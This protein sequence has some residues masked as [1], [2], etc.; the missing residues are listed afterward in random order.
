MIRGSLGCAVAVVLDAWL[1]TWV[2]TAHPGPLYLAGFT[3]SHSILCALFAIGIVR[4][5]PAPYRIRARSSALFVF[6]LVLFIPVFG[7][8]YLGILLVPALH[9]GRPTVAGTRHAEVCALPAI[10]VEMRGNDVARGTDLPG[11]LRFATDPEKRIA[12]LIATLS[13]DDR[14]AVR[15]LRLALKDPEDEIRLLAYA[16]LTRKEKAI[17][18]RI[19]DHQAEKDTGVSKHQIY[20][21]HKALAHDYWELAHIGGSQ[22]STMLSLCARAREYVELALQYGPDDAGLR[23]LHARILLTEQRLDDAADAFAQAQ[24]AGMDPRK[25]APFLAEIAFMRRDY[26]GVKT[27]LDGAG[28]RNSSRLTNISRYW[29]NENAAV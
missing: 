28:N 25:T 12:S 8:F 29:R 10:P 2:A 5:M 9:L 11:A 14:E 21:K 23:F 7:M 4:C 16:L 18:G 24:S 17:E 19:R 3:L 26:A 1:I 20:L 27:L 13:L 15:L 6:A 22:G